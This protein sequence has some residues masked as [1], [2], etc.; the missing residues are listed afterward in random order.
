MNDLITVILADNKERRTVGGPS[1]A[2]MWP[3][4]L[5]EQECEAPRSHE[6][7]WPG[8]K[9]NSL[10]GLACQTMINPLKKIM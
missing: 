10:N 8:Y 7:S 2:G 3:F 4:M 9:A 5:T 1:V 6:A